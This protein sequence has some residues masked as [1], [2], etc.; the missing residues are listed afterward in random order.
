MKEVKFECYVLKYDKA[1]VSNGYDEWIYDTSI[2]K[3]HNGNV[4]PLI[5]NYQHHNPES[6][7]GNA[8]LEIKPDGMYA[9]CTLLMDDEEKLNYT[10]QLINDREVQLAPYVIGVKRYGKKVVKGRVS[11]VSLILDR[12]DKDDAYYPVIKD[13]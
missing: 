7:L 13:I 9:Y 1:F 8:T 5:W 12:I 6:V 10:L 4:V 11:E 3:D 2:F